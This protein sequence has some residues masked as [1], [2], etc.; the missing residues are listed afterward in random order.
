M[1]CCMAHC[2]QHK[3]KIKIQNWKAGLIPGN[4]KD[5]ELTIYFKN[6]LKELVGNKCPECG[7]GEQNPITKK[8]TLTIDH[9]NGDSTDNTY[10]NLRVL[11][12]NCHTLTPTFNQL[13]RGNGK[14]YTP[15]QRTRKAM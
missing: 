1:Y 13:N 7:W 15:G 3:F 5:G 12:Y 9:I 14:R 10:V 2:H 11:C 6:Y 8:V 4:G